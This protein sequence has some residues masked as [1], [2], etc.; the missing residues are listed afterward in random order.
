MEDG[1][2][3]LRVAPGQVVVDGDDVDAPAGEPVEGRRQR[4]DKG[5]AFAR[6]HLGDLAL[7]EHGAAH[8]LDVEVAHRQGPPHR[9]AGAREHL[10]Q[11]VVHGRLQPLVLP[12]PALLLQVPAALRVA[13]LVLVLR[14]PEVGL[15]LGELGADLVGARAD[16]GVGLALD[17]GFERARG[18]DEGLEPLDLAVV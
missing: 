16:L 4:R 5:L 13:L 10:G 8:Q 2:H 6:P 3:P 1:A 11:D 12:L 17:L 7:V 15:H 14:R 18:I 9:L